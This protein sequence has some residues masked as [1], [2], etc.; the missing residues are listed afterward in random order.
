MDLVKYPAQP[1]QVQT[2]FR[3]VAIPTTI[4]PNKPR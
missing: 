2:F 1:A 4:V 3:L